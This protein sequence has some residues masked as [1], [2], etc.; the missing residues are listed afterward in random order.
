MDRGYVVDWQ[1]QDSAAPAAGVH[2]IEIREVYRRLKLLE[3]QAM[4]LLSQVAADPRRE[5]VRRLLTSFEV[6]IAGL[7]ADLAWRRM[8]TPS[9]PPDELGAVA[10]MARTPELP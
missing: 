1:I 4:R 2:P 6:E 3:A 10:C 9:G 7:R 8:E 5:N